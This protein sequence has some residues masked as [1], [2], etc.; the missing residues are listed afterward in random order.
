MLEIVHQGYFILSALFFLALT[1]IACYYFHRIYRHTPISPSVASHLSLSS[2]IFALLLSRGIF[3]AGAALD[4]SALFFRRQLYETQAGVLIELPTFVLLCVWE[5]L[6]TLLV[7][8]YFRDVAT[9]SSQSLTTSEGGR[10]SRPGRLGT[11][12][13][14]VLLWWRHQ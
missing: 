12:A 8:L 9:V 4:S 6:P 7:I 2:L 10:G 13:A 14:L 3:D 11:L 5:V 1:L